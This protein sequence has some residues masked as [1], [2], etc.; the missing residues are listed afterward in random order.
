MAYIPDCEHDIFVSYAH[1]DNEPL[2]GVEH[3]W[4]TTLVEGLQT[5]LAMKLGRSDAYSLW[6]DYQLPRHEDVSG[7]LTEALR[8]T[9]T[10]VVILSPGYVAS[11]WC[12]RERN[13]F[14][15]LVRERVR[16]GSRVFVVELARVDERPDEFGELI[17]YRFWVPA[18]ADAPVRILGMPRPNPDDLRYYDRLTELSSELAAELVRLRDAAGVT[19]NRQAADAV[20]PDRA[21]TQ[22]PT[23]HRTVFL[24]EVT[25]DLDSRRDAVKR[26]LDQAGVRVLPISFYALERTAFEK[27]LLRDLAESDIF[28]Q[29]L[30]A[31][32]GKPRPDVPQGYARLQYELA[33]AAGMEIV[34]WRDP[35]LELDSVDD[36]EHRELLTLETVRSESLEEFKRAVKSCA[37][38]R[39]EQ[40]PLPRTGF[41]TFVFVDA[42]KGDLHLAEAVCDELDRCG[43][44]ISLPISDG[45]PAE[46]RKDLEANLLTCDALIVIYGQSTVRW[47]REQL[48]QC[49]KVLYRR[50]QP[51][52]A[53]AVYEGPPEEKN[54]LNLRLRNMRILNCRDGLHPEELRSF[55]NCTQLT[56]PS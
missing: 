8:R 48:M 45:T 2:P 47:V 15:S 21:G 53:L 3:G 30:S 26:Y 22:A 19:T 13:T 9:A 7:Q 40:P 6:M 42:E 11:E 33:K 10:L 17:G 49:R 51:L 18:S 16:S 56:A 52:P 1:V 20:E 29:L 14:L 50:D 54:P 5:K 24:A 36:A 38:E 27:A 4:V 44:D 43:A 35:D 28:V 55:L 23:Q 32:P 25:D 31:I 12:G 39:E 41:S 46:I 37:T 34:Q